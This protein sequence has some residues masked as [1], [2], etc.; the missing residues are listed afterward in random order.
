M[1]SL[2]VA[3]VGLSVRIER[4]Q[5]PILVQLEK[6]SPSTS[7]ITFMHQGLKF[8]ASPFTSTCI[9]P[10]GLGWGSWAICSCLNCHDRYF[11]FI[12][13]YPQSPY[14]FTAEIPSDHQF[15]P[16][17]RLGLYQLGLMAENMYN[18]DDELGTGPIQ[19]QLIKSPKILS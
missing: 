11:L 3:L 4:R 7:S 17:R 15:L 2:V 13:S 5:F 6:N 10:W 1:S 19:L 14:R 16:I 8:P 18:L 12:L 9:R